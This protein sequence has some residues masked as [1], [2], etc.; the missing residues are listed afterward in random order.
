MIEI[1]DYSKVIKGKTVLKNIN[2]K[3]E[4]GKIYG[5][6][7]RNGSGK[8]MLIRAMAGLIYPTTGEIIVN[9]KVLHKDIS[10]P[11]N[12]GVMIENINMYPMYDGITNLKILA[13]IRN[14]IGIEEIKKTMVQ[15]GLNPE[16]NTKVGRY[17]LGM[18]QKLA[19]AQ[20]IMEDPDILLLDEPT[21]AL[22]EYSVSEIR[23]MLLL[24]KERKATIVIASH[25]RED[26]EVLADKIVEMDAG[27][28]II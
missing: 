21:N 23:K 20:A 6:H 11:E 25:N 1:N 2:Y 19:I 15:V 7:G 28:L 8:T 24:K 3:F 14:K 16:D 4:D 27:K 18:K 5:L 12:L 17:S 13:Q 9:N 22:D 26:L 10:F